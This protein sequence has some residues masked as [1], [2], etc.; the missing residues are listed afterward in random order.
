MRDATDAELADRVDGAGRLSSPTSRALA[1]SSHVA[2]A[3]MYDNTIAVTSYESLVRNQ[4]VYVKTNAHLKTFSMRHAVNVSS[5]VVE[6]DRETYARQINWSPELCRV[7]PSRPGANS[8]TPRH[9]GPAN[10]DYSPRPKPAFLQGIDPKKEVPNTAPPCGIS[11]SYDGSI[12]GLRFNPYR[13]GS[14]SMTIH[15]SLDGFIVNGRPETFTTAL[16]IKIGQVPPPVFTSVHLPEDLDA[17]GGDEVSAVGYNLPAVGAQSLVLEVM[18]AAKTLVWPEDPRPP[19][20][21]ECV[22]HADGVCGQARPRHGGRG[23]PVHVGQGRH[24]HLGGHL[25][26]RRRRAHL[27]VARQ[28]GRLA[29]RLPNRRRRVGRR[30]GAADHL[31]VGRRADGRRFAEA[32]HGPRALCARHRHARRQDY[33]ARR[34]CGAFF[35]H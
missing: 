19:D 18:T 26:P 12:L 20:A 4:F 3:V 22:R 29:G 6:F 2:E 1:D 24:A 8:Y 17:N 35:H 5:V 9:R 32:R 25:P 10:P 15:F 33:G 7:A 27:Q 16:H 28:W 14:G 11:F 21:H 34:E 23:H 31:W 13:V 30:G